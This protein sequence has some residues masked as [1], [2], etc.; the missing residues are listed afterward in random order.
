MKQ[1]GK[2]IGLYI[3]LS[4][5]LLGLDQWVKAWVYQNLRGQAP[6]VW[7]PNVF[8]LT[9]VENTG[10]AFGMLA[11]KSWLF[12]VVTPLSLLL[13]GYILYRASRK[14]EDWPVRLSCLL[15]IAG[16]LGNLID[17]LARGFVV[18]MFYFKLIN[19]AVFNV[20]DAYIVIGVIVMAAM[21]LF[22][23]EVGERLF[24]EK[25]RKGGEQD[26]A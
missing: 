4:A 10:A 23:P 2:K 16:A 26:H 14:K 8:E 19:F 7:I 24:P 21:I 3:L 18:D 20:A 5:G 15:I 9:Y 6:M 13:M 25:K 1:S 22:R 17:R 11:G 12:Y